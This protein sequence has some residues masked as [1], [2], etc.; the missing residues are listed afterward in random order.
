M[1]TAL[2]SFVSLARSE[3]WAARRITTIVDPYT[4]FFIV[5]YEH[6]SFFLSHTYELIDNF[7][8]IHTLGFS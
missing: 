1:S 3:Q 2:S 5:L 6:F 4:R 7:S 8:F